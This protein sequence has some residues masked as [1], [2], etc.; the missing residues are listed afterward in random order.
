MTAATPRADA[1]GFLLPGAGG[2]SPG[3]HERPGATHALTTTLPPVRRAQ[4]RAPGP[5][6]EVR[7]SRPTTGGPA[8]NT[9]VPSPEPECTS[10][11]SLWS[12]STGTSESNCRSTGPAR[13]EL[14]AARLGGLP[15]A[16]RTDGLSDALGWEP[17]GNTTC[18]GGV[19][20]T[21]P[22]RSGRAGWPGSGDTRGELRRSR[23]SWGL[24]A[25]HRARR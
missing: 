15:E 24:P 4:P 14:G 9:S 20:R 18:T 13:T 21:R 25:R 11:P 12:T 10:E 2:I 17:G 5:P 1:Q 7:S 6:T 3:P 19:A 16:Q 22:T 23:A 8:A